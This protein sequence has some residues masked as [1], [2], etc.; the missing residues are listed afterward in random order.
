MPDQLAS[1]AFMTNHSKYLSETKRGAS[2]FFTMEKMQL[3]GPHQLGGCA[4]QVKVPMYK[5]EGMAKLNTHLWPV[6]IW[7]FAYLSVCEFGSQYAVYCMHYET[8]WFS[9][10]GPRP[11]QSAP[12]L[13]MSGS[14]Y[15]LW[16]VILLLRSPSGLHRDLGTLAHLSQSVRGHLCCVSAPRVSLIMPCGR[17]WPASPYAPL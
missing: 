16:K 5:Y 12:S 2:S 14:L 1:S 7:G 3:H 17:V 11:R 10:A 6:N 15:E 8:G 4:W 13:G 9:L